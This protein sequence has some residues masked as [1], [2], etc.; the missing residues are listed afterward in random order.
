LGGEDPKIGYVFVYCSSLA[1]SVEFGSGPS[2]YVRGYEVVGELFSELI[3]GA[4][5]EG[6]FLVFVVVE[7][8]FPSSCDP[9]SHVGHGEDDFL[10]IGVIGA[11]V[12][13]KVEVYI[14][15]EWLDF[16]SFAGE[17]LG[18]VQ[19]DFFD[20][21]GH[22]DVGFGAR[23]RGLGFC[24][25]YWCRVRVQVWVRVRGGSYSW[26]GQ[27]VRFGFRFF[28]IFVGFF[29]FFLVLFFEVVKGVFLTFGLFCFV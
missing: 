22:F 14:A 13:G 17:W 8:F 11:L 6:P 2:G 12:Q 23:F 3:P 29:K 5:G 20:D 1:E 27:C 24:L 26:R 4:G 7:S 10:E 21:G 19:S 15:K 16:F 18:R 28:R 25:W 9:F